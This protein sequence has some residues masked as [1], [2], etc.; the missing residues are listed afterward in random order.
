MIKGDITQKNEPIEITRKQFWDLST[1]DDSDPSPKYCNN[2]G[3]LASEKFKKK[4]TYKQDGLVFQP[5]N[6]VQL[7]YYFIFL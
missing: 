4:L 7:S 5:V 1:L 2:A 6:D 3:Y